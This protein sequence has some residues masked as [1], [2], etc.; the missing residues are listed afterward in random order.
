MDTILDYAYFRL[1]LRCT[2]SIVSIVLLQYLYKSKNMGVSYYV[3]LNY[4]PENAAFLFSKNAVVPS[5]KSW[6]PKQFPNCF[7]SVLKPSIPSL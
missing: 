6:V 1:V 4:L 5:L 7:I 2:T 3:N